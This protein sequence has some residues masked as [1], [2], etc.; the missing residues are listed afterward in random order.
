MP[1]EPPPSPWVFGAPDPRADDLVALGADLDPGTLLAAYRA[2]CFPM[3]VEGEL[4]WWSPVERG[5]LE[6]DGLK[7]SK[8]LRRSCRDFEIRVDT[9]FRDVIDG[10][11]D[12][13]R[14]GAWITTEIRDAYVELHRIGWAHSVEVWRDGELAGGLYGVAIGG[15]FAG[16]SMFH[17]VRDASKVA[18]VALVDLL[19]AAGPQGR[20]IDVQWQTDH[21]ATLG[22]VEWER[23]RY[24]AALPA[25]L[26]T[27]LP[28]IWG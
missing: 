24:L 1:I 10:C 4:G 11:A 14:D 3:G 16:E 22:V 12:P 18:L 8:S 2:G 21:L 27:P 15:L 17:R 20:L 9:A 6:L 7:V 13:D 19:T 23:D 26:R 28:E 25:V 5:V